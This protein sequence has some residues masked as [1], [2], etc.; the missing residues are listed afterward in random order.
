MNKTRFGA[1]GNSKS[2]YK[3]NK[4]KSSL[5]ACRWLFAKGLDAY[6][7]ECTRGVKISKDFA[8]KLGKEAKACD[9]ALS[10]HAPYY[11]N[12]AA[13]NP[14]KQQ[15]SM[16]HLLQSLEA[17]NWMGARKVV[18]HP[19][20][21]N[22]AEEGDTREQALDRAKKLLA[23]TIEKANELELLENVYLAPETMGKKN[24]LG[25]LEEIIALCEDYPGAVYPTVD[26]GHL[27]ALGNGCLQKE[28]DFLAVFD[29]IE[30]A[31]GSE[32]CQNLHCHFSPIE[33]TVGG[34]KRHHNFSEEKYGPDFALLANVL[35]KRNYTPTIIC[36]SYDMQAEDAVTMKHIYK[37]LKRS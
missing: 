18:F 16:N 13:I 17:A 20:S 32:A 10:L 37:E 3:D 29:K 36:E 14:D 7:Y 1:G 23:A 6:E 9:I 28:E 31:L 8:V 5:E 24:Q 27:H 34:E 2:F 21:G 15:S 35:I 30:A 26:W 4:R 33:Y 12:L 11:I 19:G 25:N 22:P